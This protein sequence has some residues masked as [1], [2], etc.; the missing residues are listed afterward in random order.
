MKVILFDGVCNLCNGL[1]NWIIDHDVKNEF[2][3]AT[4]QSSYGQ[5]AIQRLKMNEESL[6]TVILIE[7]RQASFR[8]AAI[9][10]IFKHLG[11][12]YKIA[13]TFIIIPKFIRD[14]IYAF[15]AKNRYKWFGKRDI[16]RIL[17]PGLKAKFIE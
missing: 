3:F 1:V 8:S 9:L 14:W 11:Y 12:P 4:L 10:K 17:G 2:K 16:C 6:N 7:E 5:N 13:Y 15:V